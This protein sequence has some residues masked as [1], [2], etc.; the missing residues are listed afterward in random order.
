MATLTAAGGQG[1]YAFATGAGAPPSGLTLSAAGEISGT[2]T[3][4]GTFNFTAVATDANGQTGAR[5]YSI[6]IGMPTLAI[7]PASIPTATAGSPYTCLL[8]TSR[9]V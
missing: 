3:A 1:P 6:T 7:T 5:S 8:Y 9:C 2:P 4:S